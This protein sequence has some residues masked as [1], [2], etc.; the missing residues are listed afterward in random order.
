MAYHVSEL[1]CC[2]WYFFLCKDYAYPF[3][4][5]RYNIQCS[6]KIAFIILFGMFCLKL[7]E[8]TFLSV[9]WTIMFSY[10]LYYFNSELWSDLSPLKIIKNTLTVAILNFL[11]FTGGFVF[12]SDASRR[13]FAKAECFVF[14]KKRTILET[15]G[16]GPCQVLL[17]TDCW[18]HCFNNYEIILVDWV[19]SPRL[20]VKKPM[21][22]WDY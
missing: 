15:H 3:P 6:L 11:S 14:N 8:L 5:I 17:G 12:Y 18:W 10:Q 21:C 2:I 7:F 4:Q 13:D 22:S 20:L 19:R 1:L 9:T 16:S